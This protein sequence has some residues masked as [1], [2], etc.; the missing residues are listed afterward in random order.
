ML[1][2]CLLIEVTVRLDRF[3]PESS[4]HGLMR[5]FE[6]AI[7]V[8]SVPPSWTLAVHLRRGIQESRISL[9]TTDGGLV[10]PFEI[11]TSYRS[12]DENSFDA[13]CE[14]LLKNGFRETTP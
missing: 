14:W 2:V 9:R 7:V 10:V 5:R 12:N 8:P 1:E 11:K 6:T 4:E 13:E 3:R